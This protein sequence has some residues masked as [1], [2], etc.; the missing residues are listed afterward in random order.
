M[1]NIDSILQLAVG[2]IKGFKSGEK[3]FVWRHL[4]RAKSS[5]L[6][7]INQIEGKLKRG[8]VG[9]A[10]TR[11]PG[12]CWNDNCLFPSR[13]RK[14]PEDHSQAMEMRLNNV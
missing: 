4:L 11:K 6:K 5:L 1:S 12:L 9:M 13:R 8:K 10:E 14:C 7:D 3:L 2:I